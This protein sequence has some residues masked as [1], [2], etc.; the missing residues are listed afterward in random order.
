MVIA[1]ATIRLDVVV[2]VI[3]V[4][5]PCLLLSPVVMSIRTFSPPLKKQN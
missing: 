3:C 4:G 5:G 1:A 2:V